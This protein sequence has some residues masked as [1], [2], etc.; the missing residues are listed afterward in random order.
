M[1]V[2]A[3][4]TAGSG[5]FAAVYDH[6]SGSVCSAG[7]VIG[8]GHAEQLM[9]FV[10]EALARAGTKLSDIDRIAVT[11]GPGSFTGIRVGVAAARGLALALDRPAVGISTLQVL[12][13]SA[14]GIS[15][16]RPILAVMD[17]K[18]GDLYCQS[19]AA[20]GSATMEPAVL[21]LETA[22]ETFA[23]FSG[24]V[25]GSG[26]GLLKGSDAAVVGDRFDITVVAKLGALAD[27]SLGKPKPLYLRGADA[28]PQTGYALARA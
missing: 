16:G 26:A 22:R 3:L 18:R 6:G 21:T 4:D 10:D 23:G 12:A 20:T 24:V 9:S 28:K 13:Q 2:L 14:A 17:G 8:K 19:F 15:P 27:P 5:C 1:I 7:A 11:V 25:T